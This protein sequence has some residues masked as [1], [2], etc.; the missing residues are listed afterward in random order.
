MGFN[1]IS[2]IINSVVGIIGIVVGVIGWK[3]LTAAVKIKNINK[4]IQNSTVNQAQTI[5][6]NNGLD[7]YAVIKISRE[8]TQEELSEIIQRI[9]NAEEVIKNTKDEIDKSPHIYVGEEEPRNAKNNDIW[10]S[11]K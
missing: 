7:T 3:S 4:D 2:T 5:T 10:I 6:V 8:T 9:S 1:E 11:L